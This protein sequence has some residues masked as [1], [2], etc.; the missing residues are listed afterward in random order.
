MQ[1]S[2]I[3]PQTVQLPKVTELIDDTAASGSCIFSV[4]AD[5][6]LLGRAWVNGKPGN[7]GI[8]RASKRRG[9]ELLIYCAA[10]SADNRPDSQ[11]RT[12]RLSSM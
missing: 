5:P 10:T 1:Y 12:A 6:S 7:L 3:K 8:S 2:I 9:W 4:V 11:W